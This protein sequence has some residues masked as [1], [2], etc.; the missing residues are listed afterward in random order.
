MLKFFKILKYPLT[1]YQIETK[2]V[3][4]QDLSSILTQNFSYK[5]FSFL[6]N[7]KTRLKG[8]MNNIEFREIFEFIKI[9]L[10]KKKLGKQQA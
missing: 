3:S 1:K 6:K 9:C 10:G 5:I 8:N 4:F 2:T 7:L